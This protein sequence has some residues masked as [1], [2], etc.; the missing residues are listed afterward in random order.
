MGV[1]VRVAVRLGVR[2]PEPVRL[3]VRVAVAEALS[4]RVPEAV[5]LADRVVVP[6]NS[7]GWVDPTGGHMGGPRAQ[8]LGC[9]M[10]KWSEFLTEGGGY[11]KNINK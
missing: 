6:C 7:N 4:V 3:A 9:H 2:V 11:H 10:A 1:A 8:T 5:G